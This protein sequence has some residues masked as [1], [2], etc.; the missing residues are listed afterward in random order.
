MYTVFIN[1][2]PLILA[3]NPTLFDKDTKIINFEEKDSIFDEIQ[4]LL[5]E[6][7]LQSICIHH[8]E[9][10]LLWKSFKNTFKIIKAA[11]GLVQNN[12]KETLF[13]K[14]FGLWDLPKGKIEKGE[15]KKATA[16]REVEE[17]CN[18]FNLEIT[19]S[20]PTTYHIYYSKKEKPILKIVYWYAMTCKNKTHNLIPQIEEGIEEVVWKNDIET[21]KAL[22]NTYKNIQLLF[23]QNSPFN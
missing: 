3:A 1:E 4:F 14:R 10:K 6:T 7:S 5:N 22:T 2:K 9:I 18:I 19:K 11:G 20:L 13:I 23:S 8:R 12:Q 16:L 15:N 17:E 21:Q